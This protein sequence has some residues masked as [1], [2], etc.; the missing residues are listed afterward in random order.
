MIEI[1]ESRSGVQKSRMGL[2][3]MLYCFLAGNSEFFPAIFP[4]VSKDSAAIG[5]SHSFTESVFILSF[6][7]GR[8]KCTFHRIIK[9]ASKN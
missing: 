3:F 2:L 9:L 8:L 1:N 6:C 7:S 5:G 4:A